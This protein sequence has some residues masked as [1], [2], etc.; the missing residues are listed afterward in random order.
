MERRLRKGRDCQA[1]V[2]A[3]PT[4]VAFSPSLYNE[5][6]EGRG[7]GWHVQNIVAS[8]GSNTPSRA[9]RAGQ[10]ARRMKFGRR[11]EA[12]MSCLSSRPRTPLVL[13][14]RK[15]M[16]NEVAS[17]SR[18]VVPLDTLETSTGLKPPL[19]ETSEV[20]GR[21][22]GTWTKR[23]ASR[24]QQLWWQSES[25]SLTRRSICRWAQVRMAVSSEGLR[26][27][28]VSAGGR[29]AVPDDTGVM[30]SG[31]GSSLGDSLSQGLRNA[32]ASP[33]LG[34]VMMRKAL[35]D[36][37]LKRPPGQQ[38]KWTEGILA[39]RPVG[40]TVA[41]LGDHL[42]RLVTTPGDDGFVPAPGLA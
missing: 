32:A 14:R 7:E 37:S 5:I 17:P 21:I 11:A 36:S 2:P 9:V 23:L 28:H 30:P 24:C 29:L 8:L 18:L 4:S 12:Q 39:G 10:G 25:Q 22:T 16:R 34:N 33:T 20:D 42:G 40:S 31:L 27:S 26:Y 38:G 35:G 6:P 3:T 19:H 41:Q 1:H 13:W 15:P